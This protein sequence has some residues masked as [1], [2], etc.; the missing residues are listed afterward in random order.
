MLSHNSN[1]RLQLQVLATYHDNCRPLHI[2]MHF[3]AYLTHNNSNR[4]TIQAHFC[5]KEEKE[6]E[7]SSTAAA[8]AAAAED[9]R[10]RR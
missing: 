9:K 5:E 6:V 4:G 2:N 8:A 10:S 3:D 7:C 1:K